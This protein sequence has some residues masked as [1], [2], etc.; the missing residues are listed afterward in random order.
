MKNNINDKI[1]ES[2]DQFLLKLKLTDFK[3]M[4]DDPDENLEK[5][6]LLLVDLLTINEDERIAIE[7]QLD[8]VINKGYSIS[9]GDDSTWKYRAERALAFRKKNITKLQ[10]MLHLLNGKLKILHKEESKELVD[11]NRIF[12]SVCKHTLDSETFSHV[13]QITK[14]VF[15]MLAPMTEYEYHRFIMWKNVFSE[16]NPNNYGY[17]KVAELYKIL[18]KKELHP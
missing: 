2:N 10:K 15:E 13:E 6:K 16:K 8:L 5:M 7:T 9:S 4:I 18:G 14:D 11:R 17:K 3:K 12:W 1:G